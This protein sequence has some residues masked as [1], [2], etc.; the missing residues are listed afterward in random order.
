MSFSLESFFLSSLPFPSLFSFPVFVAPLS[1][2]EH[3][4]GQGEWKQK[5]KFFLSL[6]FPLLSPSNEVLT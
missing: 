3:G 5:T 1:S 6:S 2:D 4:T